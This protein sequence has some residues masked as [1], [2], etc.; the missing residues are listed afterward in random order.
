[1][2]VAGRER[3]VGAV[4]APA[5]AATGFV[6][7]D[8]V[9]AVRVGA[10]TAHHV[11]DDFVVDVLAFVAFVGDERFAGAGEGGDPP[12]VVAEHAVA[13]DHVV[14]GAVEDDPDAGRVVHGL[15]AE[16]AEALGDGVERRAREEVVVVVPEHVVAFDHVPAVRLVALAVERVGDDPGAVVVEG[17][18]D[19][20]HVLR[21][22]AGVAEDVF[23]ALV[24]LQ[25][26]PLRFRLARFAAV[27]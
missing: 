7:P 10:F 20:P 21:V 12:L 14:V 18:F 23:V 5:V 11:F 19:D 27:D 17:V 2:A 4:G 22:G 3:R 6:V 25:Q 13:A 9:F 16:F 26:R 15:A 24:V 1:F 8:V